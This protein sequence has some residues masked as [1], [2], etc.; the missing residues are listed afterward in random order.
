MDADTAEIVEAVARALCFRETTDHDD[1]CFAGCAAHG[2]CVGKLNAY[3]RAIGR[4]A[5]AAARPFILEEAA[6]VAEAHYANHPATSVRAVNYRH[7]GRRIAGA[8]RS[9]SGEGLDDK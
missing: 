1:R 4:E 2:R 3:W 9:L 7:A 6:K 5:I 8:I